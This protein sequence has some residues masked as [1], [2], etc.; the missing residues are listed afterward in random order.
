[1]VGRMGVAHAQL[2]EYGSHSRQAGA[3]E[4]WAGGVQPPH[5]HLHQEGQLGGNLRREEGLGGKLGPGIDPM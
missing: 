1:M 3:L 4:R 5:H 2:L